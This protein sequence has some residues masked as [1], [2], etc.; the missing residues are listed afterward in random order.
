MKNIGD[1][2]SSRAGRRHG[3][4]AEESPSRAGQARRAPREPARD[5]RG[6]AGQPGRASMPCAA[7]PH[8]FRESAPPPGMQECSE[9]VLTSK[10]NAGGRKPP[11]APGSARRQRSRTLRGL[12]T[13]E[14]R[15]PASGT[16]QYPPSRHPCHNPG[17]SASLTP[18][19]LAA[20]ARGKP[21]F[22]AVFGVG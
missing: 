4:K 5:G 18:V 20:T 17:R 9:P 12:Y 21:G 14:D 13:C 6:V 22:V 8:L 10:D 11:P 16:C 3:G 7:G 19:G 1:P 15:E 2:A